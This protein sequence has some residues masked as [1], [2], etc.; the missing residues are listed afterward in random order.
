MSFTTISQ[1]RPGGISDTLQYL[2]ERATS[3]I[4][5]KSARGIAGFV[6]DIPRDD[7]IRLATDVTDHVTEDN[8]FINDHV[9]NLPIEVT[10]SGYQGELVFRGQEG[11]AGGFE[12]LQNRLETVEAY[13]GSLTPGFVQQAQAVVGQQQRALSAINQTLAQA[14]NIVGLFEGADPEA[15]RQEQ[16]Y[17]QLFALRAAR[18]PV[19]LQTP[20]AYF[21]SMIITNIAFR[22]TEETQDISEISVTLK[23]FRVGQVQTVAF[24]ETLFP[25][26]E[27]IQS[28]EQEDQGVVRG[29]DE[30]VSLLF[31][32]AQEL[33]VIQ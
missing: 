17:Q 6:F 9:V 10:L 33:G 14:Q 25:P 2:D 4:A 1:S 3:V 31:G 29:R 26:R 22:Q 5:P 8:T 20:W 21:D 28:T 15:T 18:E 7:D 32:A 16:A 23:E 24:D 11:I 30:N 12:E 19:T 13:L 27:E